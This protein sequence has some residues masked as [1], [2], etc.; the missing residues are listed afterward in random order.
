MTR[1]SVSGFE[2]GLGFGLGLGLGFWLGFVLGLGLTLGLGLGFGLGF[3]LSDRVG[4][5]HTKL[6]EEWNSPDQ[7]QSASF[8]STV[9]LTPFSVLCYE[10]NAMY[11]IE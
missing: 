6:V 8:K 10:C 4:C 11:L 1:T 3:G 7:Y 9:K 5:L 2:P